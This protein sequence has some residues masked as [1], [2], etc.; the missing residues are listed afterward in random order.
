MAGVRGCTWLGQSSLFHLMSLIQSSLNVFLQI[1]LHDQVRPENTEGLFFTIESMYWPG[2]RSFHRGWHTS[3]KSSC[4]HGG[5]W[6]EIWPSGSFASPLRYAD[7]PGG[8]KNTKTRDT[9]VK[10]ITLL[11]LPLK[12][13]TSS[14]NLSEWT[15]VRRVHSK[16]KGQRLLPELPVPKCPCEGRFTCHEKE[17]RKYI[18][19][20]VP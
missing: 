19:V 17:K 16:P 13:G 1:N 18:K 4:L 5:L 12:R 3:A 14:L 2:V 8:K 20:F 6:Q 11:L 9:Q 7:S 10:H 15:H